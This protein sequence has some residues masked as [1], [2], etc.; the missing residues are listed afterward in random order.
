VAESRELER[1]AEI[2]AL[3]KRLADLE[4]TCDKWMR[5]EVTD[6]GLIAFLAII[7]KDL[8][9]HIIKEDAEQKGT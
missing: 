9:N 7:T 4:V 2:R 5:D 1:I 8:M 6:R 3:E